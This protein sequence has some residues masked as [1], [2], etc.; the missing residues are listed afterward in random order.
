MKPPKDTRAPDGAIAEGERYVRKGG[1]VKFGG[2]WWQSDDLLPFVGKPV[3]CGNMDY[4]RTECDF[5]WIVWRDD[6]P[7]PANRSNR[8]ICRIKQFQ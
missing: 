7:L 5:C 3:D 6:K 4:W 8:M 1:R 2:R